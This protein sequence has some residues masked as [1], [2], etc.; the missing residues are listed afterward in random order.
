MFANNPCTLLRE[1]QSR[2]DAHGIQLLADTP[3]DAPYVLYRH[4]SEQSA[5]AVDIG[6]INNSTCLPLPFLGGMICQ[7]SECF[8]LRDAN[9]DRQVRTLQNCSADL[10]PEVS[11]VPAVANASQ[12]AKSFID[13]VNFDAGAHFFQRCHYPVGHVGI[14]FIVAAEADNTSASE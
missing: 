6:Q 8:R 5:L 14:Q 9:T 4:D 12:V 1:V 10:F 7:L 3:A 2:F 11:Q 13:T